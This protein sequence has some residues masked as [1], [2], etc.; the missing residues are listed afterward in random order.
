MPP[1]KSNE[2]GSTEALTRP[3]KLWNWAMNSVV[4]PSRTQGETDDPGED[5]E[6]PGGRERGRAA[7]VRPGRDDV[8]LTFA[9]AAVTRTASAR[10]A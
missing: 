5:A 7:D 1:L 10:A 2:T 9:T 6:V 4:L 8:T 3:V